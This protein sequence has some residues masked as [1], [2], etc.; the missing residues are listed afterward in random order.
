MSTLT[1]LTT[2]RFPPAKPRSRLEDLLAHLADVRTGEGVGAL[3]FAFNLF[4]LLARI[5]C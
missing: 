2:I 5:T 4:L 3:L 1:S